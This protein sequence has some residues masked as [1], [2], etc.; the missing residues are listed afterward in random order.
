MEAM[1]AKKKYR[2]DQK[3]Q[4]EAKWWLKRKEVIK[5]EKNVPAFSSLLNYTMCRKL[6]QLNS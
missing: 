2:D 4:D 1:S 6:L 5:R 3:S